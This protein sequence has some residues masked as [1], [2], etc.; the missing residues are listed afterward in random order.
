[1]DEFVIKPLGP[2]TWDDFAQLIKRQGNASWGAPGCG[3][4]GSMPTTM[5][6]TL[7]ATTAPH[8]RSDW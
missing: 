1:M 7:A 5:P 3:V 6:A 8:A 4:C 2:D